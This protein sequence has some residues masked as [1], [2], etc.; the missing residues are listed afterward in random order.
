[1]GAAFEEAMREAVCHGRQS[2]KTKAFYRFALS[3]L[4]LGCWLSAGSLLSSWGP[5]WLIALA[6]AAWTVT[7]ALALAATRVDHSAWIYAG[8]LVLAVFSLPHS[9]L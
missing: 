4:S 5:D 8:L 2:V 9:V 1:M 3:V 7:S 6:I